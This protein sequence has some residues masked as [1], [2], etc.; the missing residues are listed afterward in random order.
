MHVRFEEID[1]NEAQAITASAI[2][3]RLDVYSGGD[4]PRSQSGKSP[5]KPA[6]TAVASHRDL[7]AVTVVSYSSSPSF[8]VERSNLV[9]RDRSV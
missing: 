2:A 9:A 7:S 8:S 5:L 1:A 6:Q 4:W 3:T